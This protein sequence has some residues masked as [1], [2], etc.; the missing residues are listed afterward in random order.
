[1]SQIYPIPGDERARLAHDPQRPIYHFL[2]PS[3]WLND[4]NGLIQWKGRYHLFYQYNPVA[5]RWGAIHWGHAVSADLV[6]WADLPIALAPTPGAPDQDGCW[7]GCIVDDNGIP[8]LIYTGFRGETQL[9]C[10]ATSTDDLITWEKHPGNPLIAAPPPGVD[11]LAF[12]DHAVWKEGDTWYQLIGAGIKD[13]GGAALLYRSPDLRAWEYL[14]P[15]CVGDLGTT[16]EVWECP[17]FFPLGDKHVLLISPIPL[18]KTL[19]LI[20][21]YAGRRFTPET[22]GVV[23]FGGHFYASQTL[24]DD[25]GRRLMWGW[26]WEGRGEAAQVQAGWAGVM[27]L[28][29][30]LSLLPDGRLGMEPAPELALLRRSH[31]CWTDLHLDAAAPFVP[32]G[33]GGDALELIVEFALGDAAELGVK[34]RCSPD[35]REWTSIVYDRERASLAIDRRHAS[36][37][38]DCQRDACGDRLDLA[39]GEPLRL[40]IFLDRS[41]IEVFANG[42]A[43]LTGRIYP[44]LA[45][46]LE[47]E[48]F[49]RG[50]SAEVRSLD[51][52]EVRSIW[53]S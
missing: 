48:L 16:G 37:S 50:G 15:L 31:H 3:N 8:T 9:P 23:D 26:L 38:D 2:P 21:T 18:R 29:R 13:V 14:H 20:G 5:A 17:D 10:L 12:R 39:A 1:M 36:L 32:A 28:P 45:D 49:A 25:R 33:V 53:T 43:C 30:V 46:S 24:R 51:I 11:V 41:V 47:V 44:A 40:H 19:Y 35:R 34:V 22:S 27:S 4:P 52:R 6:Y 7:S 42:R